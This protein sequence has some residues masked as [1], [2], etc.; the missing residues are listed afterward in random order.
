MNYRSGLII[1]LFMVAAAGS[2]AQD[3]QFMSIARQL[4]QHGSQTVPE[5]MYLHSDR[6]YYLAGEIVWFKLYNVNAVSHLPSEVSK[7]GYVELIDRSGKPVLQAKIAMQNGTGSGSLYL[8]LT[9]SSDNY[10]LRAYTSWMKNHGGAAFF[11][12]TIAVVNTI[13]PVTSQPN[14]DTLHVTTRFFPESG[15][16]VQ[17]I[18][19]KLAFKIADQY[20]RG[21]DAK[22]IVTSDLGDTL[23]TFTPHRFGIGSFNFR[24]QAGRQYTATITLADGKTFSNSLPAVQDKGYV[25]NVTDNNDGRW[26]VR[27]QGKAQEPGQR[28]ERVYLLVHSRQQVKLSEPGYLN[29]ETDLVFYIEKSKLAEGISH[30]TLFNQNRQPVC[31]RLVFRRPGTNAVSIKSDKENYGSRE[32]VKLELGEQN[33][34]SGDYSIAVYL[35]DSLQASGDDI[36]SYIWLSSDLR[37]EVESP[38]YYLS[39]DPGVEK[40][41]DNLMLTHGWRRFRWENI[42]NDSKK[43]KP[44][45]IPEYAGHLVVI[46][47]TEAAT[48]TPAADVECY[49]TY[50]GSPFGFT[51]ARTNEQGFAYFNASE[52]YGPGE[53]VA[54]AGYQTPGKYKVD[55]LSPFSD[56]PATTRLPLLRMSKKFEQL[57]TTRSIAMQTQN[58]Y[59]VDSMRRFIAPDYSDTLPFFGRSEYTYQLDDYKRFTTMEEVLREY[60]TPINVTLRNGKLYMS[61]F[62]EV[63]RTVSHDQLLVLL[64]GVP[65]SD[66]NQIFSYDPLKVK[67]LQVI[68]RRYLIGGLNFKGIASF[69]TYHGKFDGF[70][71]TP[72]VIAVDY[73]GL[74]MQ[75][76]FYSPDYSF[77]DQRA[78]RIPDL[79]STLY[80]SPVLNKSADGKATTGFYT[81]DLKGQYQVVL[82]G[83]GKNGQPVS[84]VHSFTVK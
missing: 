44:A 4:E 14:A 62:D 30:F 28:G 8:P 59:V 15:H 23:V 9:L 29:F 63:A 58:V 76:E 41:V 53:I 51:V 84:A 49:L 16:M 67:K 2:V 72:G 46:K 66:I 60:V 83:I 20:G 38:G 75:R 70:E 78:R 65:L 13:K 11:E 37:G 3:D 74:Q 18:E 64:D 21:L 32:A 10:V 5:K 39:N 12:K 19:T 54:Q 43:F 81:S 69:E 82:Q 34:F 22:G 1:S 48:N 47:V 7:I 31:E 33:G 77:A 40:A 56:E 25:M 17:G 6:N 26:K 52:Y 42:L 50:P 61:M 35:S 68:P 45:F 79:R 80:W 73:D 55:I 57:L 24:P 71:L 36:A 27:V